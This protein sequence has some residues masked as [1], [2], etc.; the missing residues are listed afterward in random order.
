MPRGKNYVNQ[1]KGM[2]LQASEG[3]AAAVREV[4]FYGAACQRKDCIYRHDGPGAAAVSPPLKKTAATEPCMAYLA[5]VC[6]F[7]ARTCRKRHPDAE[8]AAALLAKYRQIKCRF[9]AKCKT[10]GCLY[11]HDA[12]AV[13]AANAA[14][15]HANK[16]VLGGFYGTATTKTNATA[17]N[18]RRLPS[19]QSPL[20]Q[21]NAFPPLPG[22]ALS[23]TAAE[24]QCKPDAPP[25]PA[26]VAWG[27]PAPS[28][29]AAVAPA[30]SSSSSPL[31]PPPF[32]E[33]ASG[34]PPPPVAN[35]WTSPPSPHVG[36]G[37]PP[38]PLTGAAAP[39]RASRSPPPLDPHY[40]HYLPQDYHPQQPH[41]PHPTAHAPYNYNHNHSDT[42][43]MTDLQYAAD[44]AF[45]AQQPHTAPPVP[46]WYSTAEGPYVSPSS[47]M[48]L[49]PTSAVTAA[50]AHGPELA[51][52]R[53]AKEFVPGGG[54]GAAAAHKR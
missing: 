53:H 18:R 40:Q 32:V 14:A 45:Y 41:E 12:A 36:L 3:A 48:M 54:A 24:P 9:G 2:T 26:L 25:K 27:P 39:R 43:N 35:A 23:S 6:A 34:P 29:S 11:L 17:A 7:T 1:N 4:C 49:Y 38:P 52:N 10:K 44:H 22:S 33:P 31:P 30:S 21:L 8:Q 28:F 13:T 19:V 42:Y 15:R 5:G 50:A 46:H 37:A 16:N 47:S 51:L 20:E